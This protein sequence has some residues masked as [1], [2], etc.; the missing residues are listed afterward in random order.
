MS[1]KRFPRV[2]LLLVAVS[3]FS[4]VLL[5]SAPAWADLPT[6]GRVNLLPW[7]NSWGAVAVYCVPASGGP[8]N[9]LPGGGVVVLNQNGLRIMVVQQQHVNTCL[10]QLQGMNGISATCRA[11]IKANRVDGACA[12]EF[13]NAGLLNVNRAT[14]NFLNNGICI[15]RNNPPTVPGRRTVTPRPT[16][17]GVD[18][19]SVYYLIVFPNGAMQINSLPDAEGKTFVGKWQGCG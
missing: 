16:V 2:A 13:R 6:D 1:T 12:Q 19:T 5:M 18:L 10:T 8:G 7:V 17:N 11:Q 9:N 14:V 4:F 3:A 15:L